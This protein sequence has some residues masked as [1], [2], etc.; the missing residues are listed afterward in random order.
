MFLD[1]KERA[2]CRH[3]TYRKGVARQS[4]R[5][6]YHALYA[7]VQGSSLKSSPELCTNS[8]SL[9]L[10]IRPVGLANVCGARCRI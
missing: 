9:I 6:E 5:W 8:L 7:H 2:D 4:A 1:M 3:A 10:G